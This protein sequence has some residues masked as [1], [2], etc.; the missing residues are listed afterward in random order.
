MEWEMEDGTLSV[1]VSIYLSVLSCRLSLSVLVGLAVGLAVCLSVCL[2]VSV[3]VCLCL[4]L[5]V[6]V[7]SF[8]LCLCFLTSPILH[9]PRVEG[10]S[11]LKWDLYPYETATSI[12]GYM[13]ISYLGMQGNRRL[14]H[15]PQNVGSPAQTTETWD[16]CL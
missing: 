5:S 3:F 15:Q 14:R 1:Y 6:S 8:C 2:S 16:V 10:I 4:S 12:L 13:R 7:R 11:V 9:L